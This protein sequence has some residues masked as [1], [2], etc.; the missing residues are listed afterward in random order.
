MSNVEFRRKQGRK[1]RLI[2]LQLTQRS[3]GQVRVPN[4]WPSVGRQQ[5][6]LM[7]CLGSLFRLI[8]R[9]NR[10]GECPFEKENLNKC[11][12][13]G[14][15]P[16]NYILNN[17]R[18]FNTVPTILTLAFRYYNRCRWDYPE[19][20]AAKYARGRLALPEMLA[21]FEREADLKDE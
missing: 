17:M 14:L 16:R 4:C 11:S 21:Q 19:S 1:Y 13:R 15:F 10:K 3:P 5:R 9:A 2:V 20:E 18:H 12:P 6:Y 7:R 8:R